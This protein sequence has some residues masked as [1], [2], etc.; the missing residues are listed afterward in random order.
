MPPTDPVSP[1]IMVNVNDV[2]QWAYCPRVVYYQRLYPAAASP[3]PKMEMGH[4]YQHKIRELLPRRS[5]RPY[6]FVK[7]RLEFERWLDDPVLGLQGKADLILYVLGRAAVVDFKF[8]SSG[9]TSNIKLQLTAYSLLV[10]ARMTLRPTVAFMLR[11]PDNQ[12]IPLEID[13]QLR[14]ETTKIIHDIRTMLRS[15]RL[16]PPTANRRRCVDC[17]FANLCA[18]IW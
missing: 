4:N 7:P 3:T 18:D 17:E 1:D 15:E 13:Q 16:P 10:E 2:K 8:T 14:D 12:L 9:L 11:I 5:L 6:G